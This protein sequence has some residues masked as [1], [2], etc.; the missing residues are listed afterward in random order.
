MNS[1]ARF[2]SAFKEIAWHAL[3][4]S[5]IVSLHVTDLTRGLTDDE[6]DARRAILGRNAIDF[7][8][9]APRISVQRIHTIIAVL[10]LITAIGT[11]LFQL[12]LSSLIILALSCLELGWIISHARQTKRA[13]ALL[14]TLKDC[15]TR[16]LR[17][18]RLV[19]RPASDLVLGDVIAIEAEDFV[20]VDG[21]LFVAES[22]SCRETLLTK[23][24]APFGKSIKAVETD[25]PLRMRSDMIYLGT[26]VTSGRGRAIVVAT[27]M[28]TAIS[29]LT[30]PSDRSEAG[31]SQQTAYYDE[32]LAR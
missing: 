10:L 32:L 4:I 30:S 1:M 16:I 3:P 25:T 22:L 15:P 19:T 17:N 23:K 2:Q 7:S 18:G 31:Q 28:D 26:K 20:P 8:P 24:S 9:S 21:R 11:A 29:V 27:G 12:W 13:R 6:A 14:Q 5:A